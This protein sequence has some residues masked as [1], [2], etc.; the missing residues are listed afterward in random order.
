MLLEPM[1]NRLLLKKKLILPYSMN[2]ILLNRIRY[3]FES[4]SKF[5]FSFR[6]R[7]TRK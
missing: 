2:N 1:S 3:I 7:L 4:A 5:A 6:S